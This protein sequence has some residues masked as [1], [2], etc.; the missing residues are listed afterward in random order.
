MSKTIVIRRLRAGS[1]LKLIFIGNL[2]FLLPFTA[3]MGI[4]ALFGASTITWNEQPLTGLPALLSAPVL[5]LFLAAFFSAFAWVSMFLGL[6]LYA[7]FRPLSL[8]YFPTDDT[9]GTL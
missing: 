5:G 6:W 7:Q 8:E 1:L 3:L 9:G 4:L 2:G